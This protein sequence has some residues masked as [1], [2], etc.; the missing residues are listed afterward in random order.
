MLELAR[1]SDLESINGIALQVHER[2]VSWRPD[3][4]CHTDCIFPMEYL[5][6]CIREKCL[7][8]ARLNE[9]VVGFLLFR[10][11]EMKG[12][13]NVPRKVLQLDSI[14]VEERIQNQGVGTQMMTELRA[15]ARAFGCTDLQLSVYPQND[16]AI[17]FYQ[18]CG[19]TIRNINMQCK[20]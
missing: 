9:A 20:V 16:E 2:H 1:E 19:F 15:L 7:F 12:P 13:G 14:G 10:I 18:K 5:Q 3:I 6:E 11:W 8:V 4:Y 17:A